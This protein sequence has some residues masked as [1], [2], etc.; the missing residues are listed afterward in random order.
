MRNSLY[1][2]PATRRPKN[3]ADGDLFQEATGGSRDPSS[4]RDRE[5]I[6][7]YCAVS[8]LCWRKYSTAD[9]DG[10]LAAALEQ[11]NDTSSQRLDDLRKRFDRSMRINRTLFGGHA[12]RK[13]LM[14]PGRTVLRQ[15]CLRLISRCGAIPRPSRERF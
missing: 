9:R 12:F 6:N 3:A 5:A 15:S 13:P 8:V 2:G 4:M 14:L 1:S 11:M 7:R 10:F